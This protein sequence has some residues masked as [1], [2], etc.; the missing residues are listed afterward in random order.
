MR[1][2]ATAPLEDVA[3]RTFWI[4][5]YPPLR[6]RPCAA[7]IATAQHSKPIRSVPLPLLRVG[8]A[9]G[10]VM[11]RVGLRHAPL[12]TFRL[13][14]LITDMVYDTAPLE[15]LVGP[16]PFS[17]AQGVDETVAWLREH[18]SDTRG[19]AAARR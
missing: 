5:D 9:L 12:T 17:L 4:A 10:D 7:L 13:N 19:P 8:A 1:R 3:A 14:N 18:G 15:T 11:E 2:L 16:L 6:I